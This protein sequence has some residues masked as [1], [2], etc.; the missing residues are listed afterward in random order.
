VAN[1]TT[2]EDRILTIMANALEKEA[3][4]GALAKKVAVEI[5]YILEP[6]IKE[7]VREVLSKTKVSF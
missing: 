4:H 2:E 1:Y 7:K 6:I 3:I 5:G